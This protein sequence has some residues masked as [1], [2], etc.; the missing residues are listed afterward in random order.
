MLADLRSAVA[1]PRKT[2]F[3]PCGGCDCL[4]TVDL[5][6]EVDAVSPLGLRH[7]EQRRDRPGTEGKGEAS[8]GEVGTG[9]FRIRDL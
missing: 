5:I 4:G 9:V 2:D 7:R 8:R 1:L 3:V 6:F